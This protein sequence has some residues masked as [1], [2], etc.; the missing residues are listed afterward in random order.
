MTPPDDQEGDED[1]GPLPEPIWWLAIAVF[2]GPVCMGS[3]AWLSW[4]DGLTVGSSVYLAAGLL[5]GAVLAWVS[6]RIPWA[7][8]D[9]P[10]GDAF[11]EMVGPLSFPAVFALAVFSAVGEE[12][13]FR[14][15][16]QPWLGL[17]ITALLFGAVHISDKPA[18]RI[19]PVMAF[20]MGLLLGG[21]TQWT[22]GLGA[23]I[24]L[25]FSLNLLNLHALVGPG[26]HPRGG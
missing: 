19:W 8:P 13:F 18:L 17:P 26:Q 20:G 1:S 5:A 22:G 10:M 4:T 15:I 16:L 23:A 12:L 21:L 6:Q 9:G 24:G 14:G 3:A 2:Y 25:H 7:S 11:R